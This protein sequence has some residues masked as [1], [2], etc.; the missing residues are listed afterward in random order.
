MFSVVVNIYGSLRQKVSRLKGVICREFY[1]G[2]IWDGGYMEYRLGEKAK[3][4]ESE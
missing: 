2:Y 3:A 4:R 1:Q